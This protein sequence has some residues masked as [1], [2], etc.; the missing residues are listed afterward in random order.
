MQLW[1][2][3][4]LES[5]GWTSRSEARVRDDVPVLILGFVGQAGHPDRIS[6]FQSGGRICSPPPNLKFFLCRPL[7]DWVRPTHVRE[8]NLLC[9]TD[10]G[11]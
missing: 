4:S 10:C 5:M 7:T 2:L 11:C 8:A 9:L 6:V 3:A 1:G